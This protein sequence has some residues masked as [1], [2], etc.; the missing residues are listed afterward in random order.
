MRDVFSPSRI[1]FRFATLIVAL[2][3]TGCA[4]PKARPVVPGETVAP[5]IVTAS[6]ALSEAKAEQ[7]VDRRLAPAQ[8]DEHVRELI[9][10]FRA[11]ADAPLVAGNRVSLLIDG[12]QTLAAIRKSIES[13]KHHVHVET[14]IFAD[15]EVGHEFSDLL[16]ARRRAGLEVRVIYDAIG[17]VTTP[18]A[19]FDRMREAGVEVREFRPLDPVRTPLPWKI[20]NRD[21]RKIVVVDGRIA[22]TGGIN[23]SSTYES[24][25][26]TRPG[27]ETGRDEAWRDTHVEMA[28]PVATQFQAL[29][30]ATWT[31]AGGKID[32][33]NPLYFPAPEPAGGELVAAVATD[34]D[35]KTETR[36]YATYLAVVEHSTQRLWL[37][38]AYF[39]PNKEFRQALIAAAKR[40]VDVRLIVP[41]FTD[42]GLIL[43]ASR[44]T[45]EELLEGGVRI[46]EQRY[47]LLHAKTAVIDSALS[48][49]GSANLDMRSFLHNNEVNAVVVGSGFAQ[50]LEAVFERD[51]KD[52]RELDLEKWRERPLSDKI[53]EAAS[54]LL[55][56][57]L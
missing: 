38:N 33:A 16:I 52:T 39:A 28:G 37:T 36:I 26:T 2:L 56:Y 45:F 41:S 27:P 18:G 50:R 51:L 35:D 54:S 19:F 22:F 55:S 25:S 43:H 23:I 34:A 48:M 57:W 20:N 42:S 32:N 3:C 31:R 17:S 8:D 13:A 15:D 47:A 11:Q 21:H 6:G 53:K 1:P 10:A 7:L 29:F 14:Y 49:V 30:L 12:P 46:Y 9:D 5:A 44:S 4:T 24:S 40:G